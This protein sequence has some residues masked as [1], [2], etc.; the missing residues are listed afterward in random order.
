M[1][2][3]SVLRTCINAAMSLASG[4]YRDAAA[5]PKFLHWS[6]L[7]VQLILGCSTVPRAESTGLV[8]RYRGTH[9]DR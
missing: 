1:A 6:S 5:A 2:G 9:L 3:V 4:N 7:G 8:G